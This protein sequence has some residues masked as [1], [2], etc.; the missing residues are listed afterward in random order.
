MNAVK[1][2]YSIA[3]AIE[4][5]NESEGLFTQNDFLLLA[6][7]DRFP[8]YFHHSGFL[9]VISEVSYSIGVDDVGERIPF[10]GILRLEKLLYGKAADCG[11]VF[12]AAVTPVKWFNHDYTNGGLDREKQKVQPTEGDGLVLRVSMDNKII[13]GEI[14]I[15]SL[16]IASADVRLLLQQ[17]ITQK[18]EVISVDKELKTTERFTL[19]TIIAALCDNSKIKH[20]ERGAAAQIARLTEASGAPVSDDAIREALKKIPEALENRMK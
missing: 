4:T 19:L 10:D 17:P 1:E 6:A 12:V 15:S 7:Q 8:L 16:S 11:T 9:G 14:P 20:Q 18:A 2:F 5:I 13:E 3:E